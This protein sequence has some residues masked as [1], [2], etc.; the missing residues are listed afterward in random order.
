MYIIYD[1]DELKE[2]LKNPVLTIGNFDGV[3]KGHLVL[4]DRV[5]ERAKAIQGQSVVMTFE[6][7]PIKV[8]KPGNGPPLIT[9]TRQKLDLISD[10]GIDLILCLPFTHQFASIS[11]EEFVQGILVDRL[12]IKEI[13]VGY[14]YTFGFKRQGNIQVLK[15]LG[16]KLGFRV[17]VVDPICLDDA[18]VS[19]TSIRELVQDG[20]LSEAKKLLGRDY[21][22][23]GTVVKGKN[24]GGRLLGFPTANL[25][26]ID[27]LIPKG[28][29]YAVT[30]IIN[31][32]IHYGVTNIGYNPTFGDEALS[33]ETHLLD[34]SGDIVGKTIRIN[35]IKRLREEKTYGNVKELA[36]QIAL[37]IQEAKELFNI[38]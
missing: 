17:H 23:C 36:D 14:D 16:E 26:L 5:K 28:G 32:N 3:H 6:P 31:G 7:H 9:P 25:K 8:M 1:L 22:I 18:L 15:E 29:V 12:G 11:A 34:F 2:P 20:N 30:A 24:R 4:F 35:F 10:A 27:E 38:S 19:S 13:V 33:V 37:D 21:Q